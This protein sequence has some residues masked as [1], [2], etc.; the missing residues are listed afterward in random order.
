MRVD[1]EVTPEGTETQGEP[2]GRLLV[3]ATPIGN[4]EDLSPRVRSS[5]AAADLIA[6]E[7]TRHSGRL[8]AHLGI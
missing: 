2:R 1:S 5:L 4:L 8:L 6:C 7:D 3:I